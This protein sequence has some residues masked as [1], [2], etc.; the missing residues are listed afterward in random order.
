VDH[1]RR[2]G[3]Y[4]IA[5]E[6]DVEEE[7]MAEHLRPGVY[8]DE[9]SFRAKSIEGVSTTTTGFIGPAR[10]G[11][12]DLAS[13]LITSL[14]EFERTYGDGRALQ[15]TSG[16]QPA[17]MDNY[18]WHAVRAFFAEGGT[19]LYVV[20]TF[21]AA[22]GSDGCAVGFIP[23]RPG[24]TSGSDDDFIAV[25]ARFPGLAG[26]VRVRVT[27]RLG[28]NV[29]GSL[30]DPDHPD[31]SSPTIE[32]LLPTDIV[33]ITARDADGALVGP[34]E[35][36]R[37]Q[38]RFES[39]EG[40][41]VWSFVNSGTSAEG[42]GVG[43]G[44]PPDL[45]PGTHVIQV[46]TMT[47]TLFPD[48]PEQPPTVWSGLP[49]DSEHEHLGSRDSV[50]DHFPER[51][52]PVGLA[53][54]LPIVITLGEC[55]RN[56][57]DVL[58]ALIEAAAD[59]GKDLRAQL[60]SPMSPDD[61]RSFDL[62]LTGG[63]DGVRPEAS[64]YAGEALPDSARRKGL[65]ALEDIEEISIVAAPGS[66]Y[67]MESAEY[68]NHASQIINLLIAHATEMR[69]RFAV[70]DS[71]NGHSIQQVRALR[72]KV[73]AKNAALYYPWVR[74]LD[75]ITGRENLMPPSGFVAGIY[76]RNDIDRGVWNA[77]AN[78]V[79][80]LAIGFEQLLTKG[81]QDVLNPEGI[82][83]F[84]FFEGRGFRV[85]G[86]HTISADSDWKYVNLRRY[87]IYLERSIDRGTQWTV[88]EPNDE[89][90]WG[91]I[92]RTIEDFLLN[93]WHKGALVGDKPERAY[94]VKC[95]RSTMTQNDLDNGRLVVLVGAAPSRP[96][97]FVIFRIGQW[98]ADRKG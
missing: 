85:W 8:V 6:V 93:E 21:R 75:P 4:A 86:A 92:R 48:N 26:G 42:R 77:P 91:D 47:L 30:P 27:V 65:I 45:I 12:F 7:A 23:P 71:G 33:W 81:E 2:P 64:D 3:G 66:S 67:G 17:P 58:S 44:S 82:N 63:N 53:R 84:R 36:Y 10:Y 94:F 14:A 32:A 29:L 61:A 40:R 22:T 59:Q 16:G 87:F 49:L 98:T 41:E 35:A 38:R 54:S 83:C 19:R 70:L 34:G 89:A 24:G 80:R 69:C 51:P 9:T 11:P 52:I 13:D 37:A 90:L 50:A 76:A 57:L 39:R 56:G 95:D 15:F 46:V 73:D 43:G 1:R 55:R 60:D 25:R 74:I 68:Q 79:V 78:V 72:A 97:E 88:F 5:I 20:R 18:L 28:Q 62:L 96:A 31:T